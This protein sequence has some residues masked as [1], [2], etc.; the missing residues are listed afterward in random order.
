MNQAIYKSDF[1]TRSPLMECNGFLTHGGKFKRNYMS[2]QVD[3]IELDNQI[4]L[5]L[6][7]SP[8]IG[9]GEALSVVESFTSNPYV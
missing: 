4:S 5:A 2:P 3:V 9:P 7:S 8:P 6:E 1:D